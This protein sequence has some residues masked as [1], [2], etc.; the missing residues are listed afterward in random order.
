MTLRERTAQL[1]EKCQIKHEYYDNNAEGAQ[2]SKYL[3]SPDLAPVE[4]ARR[5]WGWYN[6]MNLW[7][8]ASFNVNT[9]Q[10]AGSYVAAGLAWWQGWLCIWAGYI[11][12]GIFVSLGGRMGAMYHIS[13][14][15]AIRSSFGIYGSIWPVLNRIVLAIIWYSVQGWIGG[16]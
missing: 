3:W 5:T 1:A 10:L 13:F 11:L 14:P 2:R 16:Q 7:I 12:T 9:W 15:V 6:F 8:S 4:P